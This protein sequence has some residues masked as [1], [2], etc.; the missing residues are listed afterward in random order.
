MIIQLLKELTKIQIITE[1]KKSYHVLDQL[2]G[3]M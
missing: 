3:I 2:S 1:I